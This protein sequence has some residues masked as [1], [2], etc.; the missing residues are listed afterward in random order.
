MSLPTQKTDS[1][2]LNNPIV[3]EKSRGAFQFDLATNSACFKS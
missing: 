3:L 2:G 1:L